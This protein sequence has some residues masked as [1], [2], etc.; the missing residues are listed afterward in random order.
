MKKILIVISL[1]SLIVAG[2]FY[3]ILKNERADRITAEH[4]LA[5]K[6]KQY[7]DDLGRVVTESD[8]LRLSVRDFKKIVRQDSIFMNEYERK[9]AHANDIIKSQDKR[10]RQV[11]SVNSILMQSSGSNQV[12]YR[13][14]DTCMLK[15]IAPIHTPFFD[16]SFKIVNDSILT[17]DHIYHTGI[18]IIIDRERGRDEDGSKRFLLCRLIFPQ[19]VY[20]SSVVAEDTAAVI[21]SN[22][23]IRFKK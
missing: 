4:N 3:Y 2:V 21:T 15:E 22:V 1:I 10:I 11:E 23:F 9:L 5:A 13:L 19:W 17:V 6:T 12:V 8:E 16:A 18:D 20:S 7:K 14:N